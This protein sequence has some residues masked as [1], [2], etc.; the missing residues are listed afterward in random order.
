MQNCNSLD[1]G[2][3]MV[4]RMLSLLAAS[5][6][7]VTVA[8]S[9]GPNETC[10][11]AI[12]DALLAAVKV[13][14]INIEVEPETAIAKDRV[15]VEG[16]F[17]LP[18]LKQL[19]LGHALVP[20]LSSGASGLCRL[21]HLS[22]LCN[23]KVLSVLPSWQ[24][25][26]HLELRGLEQTDPA[27]AMQ[28]GAALAAIVK[29]LGSLQHLGLSNFHGIYAVALSGLS[30]LTHLELSHLPNLTTFPSLAGLTALRSIHFTEPLGEAPI[31]DIMSQVVASRITSLTSVHIADWGMRDLPPAIMQLPKLE[32]LVY[33]GLRLPYPFPELSRL[34][35]VTFL[36]V[37]CPDDG[38][39][40]IDLKD[41]AGMPALVEI[42]IAMCN[43]VIIHGDV[44]EYCNLADH[45]RWVNLHN[46]NVKFV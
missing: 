33:N 12:I 17:Q 20:L 10:S 9:W 34:T 5:L 31:A 40:E 32:L 27:L 42:S 38:L 14:A 18:R 1:L 35:S 3:G 29:G 19:C 23:D 37:G 6:V 30:K 8:L 22:C 13:T 11:Q 46:S 45:T 39:V 41:M 36:G 25:L 4:K 2:P 43:N 28:D 15:T 44:S 26:R 21:K 7:H 16:L 24:Q